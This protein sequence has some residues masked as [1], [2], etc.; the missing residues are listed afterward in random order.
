MEQRKSLTKLVFI[1]T[2]TKA[3]IYR[4]FNG[5]ALAS[6]LQV[7]IQ[8]HLQQSYAVGTTII[9]PVLSMRKQPLGGQVPSPQT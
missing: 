2:P 7:L 3:N 6:T 8:L 4:E 1:L 9:Y 5:P